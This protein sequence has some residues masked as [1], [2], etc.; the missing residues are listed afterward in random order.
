MYCSVYYMKKI[1]LPSKNRA[2]LYICDFN[3]YIIYMTIEHVRLS[4]I[5][6]LN[7]LSNIENNTWMNDGCVE[8]WNLF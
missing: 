5:I 1:P 7:L 6:L 3:I 4:Q 2:V 8:I